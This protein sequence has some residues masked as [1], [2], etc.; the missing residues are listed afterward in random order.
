VYIAWP[1]CT[2]IH[3]TYE[4]SVVQL[5][6]ATPTANLISICRNF[7]KVYKRLLFFNFKRFIVEIVM[8][9]RAEN[10]GSSARSRPPL[11]ATL[12]FLLAAGEKG[13]GGAACR[14]RRRRSRRHRRSHSDRRRRRRH[15]YVHRSP[16]THTYT[17]KAPTDNVSKRRTLY[18]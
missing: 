18:V 14:R 9:V 11:L 7:F 16:H 5:E 10:V 8:M 4:L 12:S 13:A 15:R 3:S 1:G 2:Y 17:L 6:E